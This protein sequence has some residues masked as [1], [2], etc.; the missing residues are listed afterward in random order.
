MAGDTTNWVL[1]VTTTLLV[2]AA[3][4]GGASTPES[5][6]QAVPSGTLAS[7]SALSL[8]AGSPTA[9][10]GAAEVAASSPRCHTAQ[11]ALSFAG[12]QDAAGTS[13]LT[14]R[15]ANTGSV[16]CLLQGF[17]GMQ[18]LDEVGQ[19][20]RTRVVPN[21]GVFSNQPPPATFSLP[22]RTAGGLKTASTFQV[23][24]SDV[25]EAQETACPDAYQLLVTPPGE[26]DALT[27]P[28]QGWSLAPCNGGE[29]NVTPVRPPGV[30]PA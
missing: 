19:P 13:F 18:M 24:Y 6:A 29:L 5:Q 8:A 1:V 4:R 14:F 7:P 20:L 3:C 21:G 9:A 2:A 10:A 22:P 17:V 15:L 26:L 28:V 23:A 12:G 25:P 11:L 16:S 27:I 30:A